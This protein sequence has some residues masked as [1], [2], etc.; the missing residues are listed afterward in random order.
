MFKRFLGGRYLR[1]A[2]AGS[3]FFM[4]LASAMA[5]NPADVRL[6]VDLKD[7]DMLA[8]TRMLFQRTGIQFVIAPATKQFNRIT[9]RLNDVTAE[10][11]IK[12]ICTA[13]GA[14]Y[15]RDELGVYTI[16]QE[17]PVA[18]VEPK[19]PVK[20]RQKILR[21]I[22][23]RQADA[24]AVYDQL[25]GGQANNMSGWD[26]IALLDRMK[27]M[28]NNAN[29]KGGFKVMGPDSN[30]FNLTPDKNNSELPVPVRNVVDSSND[31]QLPGD[32]AQQL[33]GGGGGGRGGFGGGQGG[34]GGLGGGGGQGGG[35]GLGGGGGQGGTQ[36]IAGQG[37]VPQGITNVTYDPQTNSLIVEADDDE[38]VNKLRDAIAL[39]DVAPRQVQIKVEFISVGSGVDKNLGFE[40]QF[41]RGSTFTGVTPGSFAQSGAVFLNYSTGNF[42][43]RLRAGLSENNSKV[44]SAPIIRTLNN[45]PATV[46][47][48]TTQSVFVPQ[49]I[50]TNGGGGGTSYSLQQITAGTTLSVSPRIN[51]D[52][53]V[54]VF[55]NPSVGG[56]QGN[57]VSPD[58]SQISPNTFQQGILVVARVKNNETIV[59]G[60]LTSKN[61][62]QTIN[63][64]PV[65][66]DLP[67]F[68]QF[69]RSTT[70]NV[71]N[72]ELL[73]FVT[74]SIIPDDTPNSGGP[75]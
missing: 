10:E 73:I 60:G 17:A 72:S 15:T 48:S 75:Q 53:T 52:D 40:F 56:F 41:Q 28:P 12:Y 3:A 43:M 14:Y 61:E 5:Q 21:K 19:A 20:P 36:L 32:A 39:F 42:A 6:D 18:K 49:T 29:Y 13:A 16:S 58:G 27:N 9:L 1:L 31:I 64:V 62:S 24:E 68:G 23:I 65:L 38:A 4:V 44:E 55:L 8:A 37:F 51:M 54:T 11:A 25:L 67:I 2:V 46:F 34:G 33:G 7:A 59:L 26:R 35:G 63:K 50:L 22:Q 66:A 70:K 30:V 69:F 45:M 74:P 47:S 71:T 57:S